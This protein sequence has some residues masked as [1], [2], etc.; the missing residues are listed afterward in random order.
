MIFHCLDSKIKKAK[1][2][3]GIAMAA[4][5]PEIIMPYPASK[6]TAI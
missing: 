1:P 3:K 2:T 5:V 6:A 4:R